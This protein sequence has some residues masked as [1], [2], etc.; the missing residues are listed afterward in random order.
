MLRATA[1]CTLSTSQPAKVSRPCGFFT[2]SLAQM[3]RS[4]TAC[5]FSSL[6]WPDGSTPAALAGLLSNLPG[7]ESRIIEK[8]TVLRTV[9]P[10]RAPASSFLWL[11][12]LR[13]S[14][15]TLPTSAFP[16]VYIVRSLVSQLPRLFTQDISKVRPCPG[17]ARSLLGTGASR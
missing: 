6:I 14:S 10:F 7:H 2:S 12:L 13:F 15:L 9:L 8:N 3:F 1:A 5:N 17:T 11:F 4:T 16:S